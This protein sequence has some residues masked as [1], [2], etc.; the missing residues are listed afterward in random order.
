[1]MATSTGGSPRGDAARSLELEH[2][3]RPE[4]AGGRRQS[5][6]AR[7]ATLSRTGVTAQVG[8]ARH[9]SPS[10]GARLATAAVALVNDL[11]HTLAALAAGVLNERRAELVASGTSHLSPELRRLVDAEVIGANLNLDA[12]DDDAVGAG[13]GVVG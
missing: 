6:S 8:L 4:P 2:E 9:E 3:E 12:R 1:M 5:R 13:A 11:P 7:R 10:R